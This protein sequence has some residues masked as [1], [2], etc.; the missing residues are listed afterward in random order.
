MPLRMAEYA[1]GVYRQFG[2]FARQCVLYGGEPDLQ[3][4][5]I[6]R[7]PFKHRLGQLPE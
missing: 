5:P 4:S 3:M 6:V 2:R 1:L 7:R